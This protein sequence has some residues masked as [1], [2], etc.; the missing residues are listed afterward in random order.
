MK[1]N[2][3]S[4]TLY[5]YAS[6]VNKVINAKNALSILNNFLLRL[7]GETLTITGSD[8]ENSLTATLAVTDV[9][10]GGAFC[11]EAQRFVDILK[12]IPDQGI[13]ISVDTHGNVHLTYSSGEYDFMAI[14]GADYPQYQNDEDD[15]EPQ[16]F[17]CP[18]STIARG[19]KNTIF[20]VS[21]DDYR[22]QMMGVFF[23]IKPD[24]II[25]VA[26]DTRKLVKFTDSGVAP[27]ITASCIIPTKPAQI[28]SSVFD[29]EEEVT[30]S[31][32]RKSA[33]I[34]SSSFTFNCRFIQGNFPDY[35]RVI[36]RS[37]TLTLTADRVTLLNAVRR[38]GLFVS[39]EYGLEKFRITPDSVEIKSEDNNLQMFARDKVPCSFTGESLIIGFGSNYLIEVLNIITSDDVVVDLADPGRPGIFRPSEN[40][41]NTELIMLLMPM[42]VGSF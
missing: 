22:P 19:I 13:E 34:S 42:T 33:S 5:N 32:S 24:Q 4:K 27:G 20:A 41:E 17:T 31:L 12:E 16:T 25:F 10:G 9:E 2:V 7:D 11:I 28:L 1:F 18:A 37:N 30:F 14:D 21:T 23:D 39:Q 36:P 40:A 26:T 8:V 3:S 35:N 15:S 38:V 29:G 6:A